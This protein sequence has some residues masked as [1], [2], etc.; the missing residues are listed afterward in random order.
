MSAALENAYNGSADPKKIH[1]C[2]S[3]NFRPQKERPR[4]LQYPCE[5]QF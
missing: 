3:S 5:S 1:I 2:N 4:K